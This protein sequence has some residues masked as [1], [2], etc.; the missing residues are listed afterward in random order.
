[1][2]KFRRREIPWEVVD[3]KAVDPVPLYYEYEDDDLDIV[4]VGKADTRG[5]YVFEG[6]RSKKN[7]D[8]RDA[9]VFA[10]QQ[11][12]KEAAKKGFNILLF[13]S[14]QLTVY[15]RGKQQRIEVQYTAHALG[16]LPTGRSPPF[17]GVLNPCS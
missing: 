7:I 15:R 4:T 2:F 12:L 5:T 13:E 17:M 14:W 6:N 11:L 9:V 8:P 10:Q 1:M 3:S 16:E